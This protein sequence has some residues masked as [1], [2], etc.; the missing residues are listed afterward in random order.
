MET[1]IPQVC[2]CVNVFQGLEPTTGNVQF[3]PQESG[4][5]PQEVRQTERKTNVCR[6]LLRC[7]LY[8]GVSGVESRTVSLDKDPDNVVGASRRKGSGEGRV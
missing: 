5:T 2:P 8:V 7:L 4:G 1:S 6:R 3:T